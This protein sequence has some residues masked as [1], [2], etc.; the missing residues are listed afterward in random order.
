VSE[1]KVEVVQVGKVEKHPNADTLSIADVNGYPCIVRTGEFT[2]G[3]KAVYLPIDSILPN[4]PRWAFLDGKLRVKAKK[5]RGVFSMGLL[6]ASDP[7][8]QI[9]QNV[10][11]EMGVE[12]YEPDAERIP[13]GN[14]ERDPGICPVYDIE[15]FR[16][17]KT[18]FDI[19]E[20]VWISEKIHG[21][22]ARFVFD[23][24]R[25][26]VGSRTRYKKAEEDG[27]WANVAR[28]Y[29]L[30]EKLA[31]YPMIAVYGE[32]YGNNSDMP[33]GVNRAKEGDR[34]VLFDALDV[35]SRR[36]FNVDEFLA[37]AK[38]LDLPVVP[39]LFRGPWD[40]SLISLAEGNTT[41]PGANHVREGIVI[42][43]AIE[44]QAHMGRV[45]LKLAGEGY[46]LRKGA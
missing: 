16:K 15:G 1:F 38:L 35:K 4:E 43:P 26:H 39:T 2:E 28:R 10:Q 6:T 9:G 46:L 18:A 37:F 3:D 33:Y 34:L 17:Y 42:K 23:G 27:C 30:A 13:Q 24:E 25:L 36:W 12:K 8:W 32:T 5:L 20:D 45:F 21:Q 19:G 29:A 41:M 22:N 40:P 31:A 7:A 11:L 44:R 14:D